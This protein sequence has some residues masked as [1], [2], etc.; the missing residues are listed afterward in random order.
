VQAGVPGDGTPGASQKRPSWR[1]KFLILFGFRR[2]NSGS[3]HR[4]ELACFSVRPSGRADLFFGPLPSNRGLSFVI[5]SDPSSGGYMAIII[6]LW[7]IDGLLLGLLLAICLGLDRELT[8]IQNTLESIDSKLHHPW[9][10][11]VK[12]AVQK[13]FGINA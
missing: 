4:D 5:K 3:D 8:K 6:A 10:D 12:A 1:Q 13:G 9:D 7:L 11:A 2:K